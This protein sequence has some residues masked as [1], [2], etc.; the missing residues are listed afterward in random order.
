MFDTSH[1]PVEEYV[2]GD[3]FENLQISGTVY[4]KTDEVRTV[5]AS[6]SVKGVLITHNSDVGV[7]QELVSQVFSSNPDITA[8]FG[9]NV[10]VRHP[11]VIA[12]PI[13]LE[14]VRWF[15]HLKKQD[16]LHEMSKRSLEPP[17]KL[18]LA[19]F[20]MA[21]NPSGR[22]S[23]LDASSSFATLQTADTICQ[24]TPESY[25]RYL[26]EI[27]KHK[28]VLCPE[29]NGVDTH[30]LWETLYLGR[31]PVVTRSLVTEAFASLPMIVLELW[32][33]LSRSLLETYWEAFR[34]E[35]PHYQLN[36]LFMSYWKNR[37]TTTV[38][39]GCT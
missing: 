9:Q 3:A 35:K 12:I 8:W 33:D 34:R 5:L 24:D 28:F 6:R 23:C 37:L 38:R 16:Q 19:N 30:R 14:R 13:G 20:S 32:K 1:I 25:T 18:C 4:I 17:T 15:P 10:K 36:Q 39:E 22:Q 11:K 21:T 29:G 2:D 27:L 26:T 31:I 7:E